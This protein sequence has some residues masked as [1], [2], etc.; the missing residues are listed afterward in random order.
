MNPIE[1]IDRYIAEIGKGLPR[2]N[3]MDIE[4]EILTAIE[5][6]LT[7]RSKKTGKPVDEEMTVEVLKEYGAPRKVASSYLPER[8]VIGPQLYSSFFTV[9]QVVL[10]IVAAVTLVKLGISL[11]QIELT[12]ENIFETLFLGMAEFFGA[13]FTA[14]GSILVLFAIVQRFLPEFNEKAGE[15]DPR[16]LPAATPGNRIDVGGTILE[17]FAA[18]LVVFLFNFFPQWINIGYHANGQWWIGLI[19]VDTNSTWNTTILSEAFFSYLPALT[20][21]WVLTILLDVGL[22]SRGRWE[23][24]SR[25]SAFSLKV[26]TIALAGIMLAGPALVDI[27]AEA[28]IAAGFPDPLAARLFV[29]FAEQGTILALVITTIASLVT[30][31]RLLVRLTGRNL[32]PAWEKFSHM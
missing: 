13:A 17:I 9:L 10:P 31:I 24:W 23:T 21:L 27:N 11:G 4:A 18:G 6:M 14:L 30:A 3:R 20:I 1:L 19:A 8:F 7:E 32:S 28:L 29:N 12:F 2:K 22:L 26:V 15:W 25:W 16:K 5:D